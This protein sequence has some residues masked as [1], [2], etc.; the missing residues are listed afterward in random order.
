MR[1]FKIEHYFGEFKNNLNYMDKK[2]QALEKKQIIKDV[3]TRINRGEPKQQILEELSRLYKDKVTI[4]KQLEQIPSKAMKHKYRNFNYMLAGMLLIA[5]ILDIVL[6]SKLQW[7]AYWILDVNYALSIILDAVFLVGVL[8]YRIESYSWVASRAVV[9]LIIIMVSIY[10]YTLEQINLLIFV[11]L[12]LIVLFFILGLLLGVKLCP[13]RVPKIIEVD[14]DEN[15][16]INRTI[17]VFPD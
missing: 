9:S 14:I 12:A 7:G 17:Y 1:F 16:K 6:M 3:K 15:E 4:V 13:P 11:S 5:L 2:E 10:Y 8:L